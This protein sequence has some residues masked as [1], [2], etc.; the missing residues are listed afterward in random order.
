MAD[1]RNNSDRDVDEQAIGNEEIRG[2]AAE[3]GDDEF[4]ETDDLDDEEDE[5]GGPAF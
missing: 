5:E 4:V 2:V 1:K 3:E